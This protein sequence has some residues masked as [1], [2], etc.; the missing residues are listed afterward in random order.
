[1]TSGKGAWHIGLVRI[2]RWLV[3]GEVKDGEVR[4]DNGG[5]ARIGLHFSI[6]NIVRVCVK[7][8]RR[9]R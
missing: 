7:T 5:I 6:T 2:A 8:D 1:M 9:E 3:N 4:H